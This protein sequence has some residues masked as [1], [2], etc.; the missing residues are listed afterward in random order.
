MNLKSCTSVQSQRKNEMNGL[1]ALE[2]V[3]VHMYLSVLIFW[4]KHS[5]DYCW[6]LCSLCLQLH[7]RMEILC[8]TVITS[9]LM[10]RYTEIAGVVVLAIWEL[11]LDALLQNLQHYWDKVSIGAE[12]L[13]LCVAYTFLSLCY[14]GTIESHEPSNSSAFV[15]RHTYAPGK[16]TFR[17]FRSTASFYRCSDRNKPKES[18][19]LASDLENTTS[20]KWVCKT[21]SKSVQ[22]KSDSLT[23][24]NVSEH[25]APTLRVGPCWCLQCTLYFVIYFSL[26]SKSLILLKLMNL[27]MCL[28]ERKPPI[29][30][31]FTDLR[32]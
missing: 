31:N 10:D 13:L 32:Y 22:Y 7:R 11:L 14:T 3:R 29:G 9:V 25:Q 16:R 8:F 27:Y 26:S 5:R 24:R 6:L 28:V 17:H 15:R 20:K 2:K 21:S 18:F 30:P 19:L 23:A 1:I 4:S 12:L